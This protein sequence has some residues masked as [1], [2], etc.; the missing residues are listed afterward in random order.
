MGG[1]ATSAQGKLNI[2]PARQAFLDKFLDEVDPDRT[3]PEKE[4]AKRAESA[5]LL[6]FER[7]RF[8][9]LKSQR[10]KREAGAKAK[11]VSP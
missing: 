4:R 9:R 8:K 6:Y 5:R 11:E 2:G 3:L 7:L 1:H 10:L